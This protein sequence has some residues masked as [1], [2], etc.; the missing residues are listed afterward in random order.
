[1]FK[2]FKKVPHDEYIDKI[3]K[4]CTPCELGKTI[5]SFV[6]TSDENSWSFVR[7]YT[8]SNKVQF[9]HYRHPEF[10]RKP[11]TGHVSWEHTDF[12]RQETPKKH[13]RQAPRVH[14]HHSKMDEDLI[15]N[16]SEHQR[17]TM[18][19]PHHRKDQVKY[20][21]LKF[22]KTVSWNQNIIYTRTKVQGQC[23]KL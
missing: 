15:V 8:V 4:T 10:N 9:L 5:H 19:S 3:E 22:D 14:K 1:M 11:P 20:L 21:G 7:F 12:K 6:Q 23:A 2:S 17:L 13:Y 18:K 16:Q